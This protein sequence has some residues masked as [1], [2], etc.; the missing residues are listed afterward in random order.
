MFSFSKFFLAL[1]S[2]LKPQA[3]SPSTTPS[4]SLKNFEVIK[5]PISS[6]SCE[7]AKTTPTNKPSNSNHSQT[8]HTNGTNNNTNA[9]NK[10]INSTGINN[11]GLNNNSINN[12]NNNSSIPRNRKPSYDKEDSLRSPNGFWNIVRTPKAQRRAGM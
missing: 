5:A 1:V 6:S 10:N 2:H 3:N 7:I 8:A 4:N 9:T 11:N 12:N